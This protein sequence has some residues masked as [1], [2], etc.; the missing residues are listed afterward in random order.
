MGTSASSLGP[1]N[2]SPLVPPWAEQG[3]SITIEPAS[4][5]DGHIDTDQNGSDGSQDS[6]LGNDN[7]EIDNSQ[8]QSEI[9]GP[10]HI[11]AQP[12]RFASARQAFGKYAQSGGGASQLRKSLKSYAKKSSGGGKGTSRRLANGITAASSNNSC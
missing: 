1:N 12:N 3:D 2:Q 5:T 8:V 4:G 9:P 6:E 11:E 7:N 10:A